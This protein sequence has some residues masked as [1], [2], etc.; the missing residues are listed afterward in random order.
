MC[1][2]RVYSSTMFLLI[3]FSLSSSS[4]LVTNDTFVNTTRLQLK[5]LGV[6]GHY[7]KSHFDVFKPL[8][9]ELARRG[10]NVTV[11]S[12]F[13]RSE[14]AKAK[15]LLPT[16]KDI[17]LN[18][19][20]VIYTNIIDLHMIRHNVIRV[21]NELRLLR[22]MA[23]VACKIGLNHPAVKELLQ[24]KK[25][26]DLIITESFNTDCFL[27]F[28]HKFKTPYISLSSH[29]IMP[30]LNEDMGN[31]DNPNYIPLIF[32]GLAKPMD[33]FS[34]LL[35]RVTL[36]FVKAAYEF[37]FR[38][39]D[40]C[41]ANE[42]FGPD[43]PNLREIAKRTQALL[44]NT[45]SSLHS[46]VP[47]LPNIVEVGGLHIPSRTKP[48]P[49]DV[50][51]FLDNAHEGVLYFNLGSMIK[52]TTIPREKLDTILD[53]LGSIPRKVLWKWEEDVLPRRL[54][55]VMFKKW[56]PQFDVLNHPNIKCYMG[57]GGLLGLSESV[58]VGI[59]M[60]LIPLYGDQF[61]NAAAAENRGVARILSYNNLDEHSLRCALN[62]IFN[63]TR[64]Y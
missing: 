38:F 10:H 62:E 19:D 7:G 45:H 27:G 5:I 23:D 40:Q 50:A 56:L 53:V 42:V 46:S 9:E 58:Y 4:I 15:E 48:L 14:S 22:S 21:I 61:H 59:P 28:I 29:Q 55:N 30:W 43:L 1:S 12:Y 36:S 39:Q 64:F 31:E 2:W 3:V 11:I 49:K 47:L 16:Y 6:F 20:D 37:W 8:L 34:R 57:H 32:L 60:V 41:I 33:F 35:N 54:N 13:A 51:E 17:M 25:K 24:S 44:V 18:S 26:F 63:S 52:M